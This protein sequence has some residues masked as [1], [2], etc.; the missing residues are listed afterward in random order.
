MESR[1]KRSYSSGRK[2]QPKG[3]HPVY[4]GKRPVSN[5]ARR[6]RR[7]NRIIRAV[8]AWAI[9]I[10]LVGLIAVGTFRLAAHMTTSKK[11]QF[12]AEGIE[13]LDAGDYAG[14]IGS[15]DTALE[16]SG[17]GAEEFNRDV[18]LYRADAEFL[19]KDYN[20]AIHTYDLLLEMRPDTPEYMYRQSSCY[21]RLGDTDN[22]IK[23]YQEAEALVKKDKPVPG[24]QEA[25]LAAGSAC[26]DAKE[27]DKAM[28]LYENALKD[29]MEHGEI[30]NQMGLCQMAAQD[31]QSA[32][33]SFD[34][35]YQ[36]AAAAQAAALQE[37]D[38][39]TGKETDKKET[40]DGDAGT[41]QS[42][43]TVNGESA[44]AGVA[45]ADG[46]RELLKELSYNRAVACEHLQQYDKALAMF[47][48]FVKEFGSDEDA[49][50][51]IACLKTR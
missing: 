12:R 10:F 43:E 35:G 23:R 17:K 33:D 46:S 44:P 21:A 38:R 25:L 14:A 37:K 41:T 18:L 1:G 13:K 31:Y 45:P 24:R 5:A 15:F 30:Y 47:E 2:P 9:C 7:K 26:V 48:D 36:V 28:A 49:E 3:Q 20:A 51:E 34:K 27:Y 42:G 39:K 8:I 11:R 29:G 50:H 22:A 6:R 19:L 40:K 16:K 32:Y 4:G